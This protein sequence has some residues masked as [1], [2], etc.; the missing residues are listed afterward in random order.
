M[1]EITKLYIEIGVLG[2]IAVV[3]IYLSIS[4]RRQ[5]DGKF[6][7]M[8][9]LLMKQKTIHTEE[10][11]IKATVMEE[12]I[13]IQLEKLLELTKADRS[14]LVRYHNGGRD[15][16]GNSFL[17]MS[18]SNEKN[19]VGI[20]SMQTEFKDR[21]RS[22]FGWLIN[23]LEKEDKVLINDII[24]IQDVDNN[25]YQFFSDRSIKKFYAIAIRSESKV[26]IGYI[27][28]E[29]IVNRKKDK[30]EINKLLL[31]YKNKIEMLLTM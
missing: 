17:K 27:G 3:F 14:Y 29:Y 26:V 19:G 8:F 25:T 7:E 24:E 11:D 21:F 15:L 18:M 4:S 31:E 12:H 6:N 10:E 13:D 5:M 30:E 1:A 9:T 16:N 22:M 2:T 20:S 28:L 23:K